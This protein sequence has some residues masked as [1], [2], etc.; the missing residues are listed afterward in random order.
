MNDSY[1]GFHRKFEGFDRIYSPADLISTYPPYEI[2]GMP[3]GATVR[4][5]PGIYLGGDQVLIE[6]PL[7]FPKESVD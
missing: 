1:T 4:I 3:I 2:S 5:I 6:K 7:P